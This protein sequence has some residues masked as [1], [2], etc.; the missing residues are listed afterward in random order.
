MVNVSVSEMT[1]S[2]FSRICLEAAAWSVPILAGACAVTG[3]GIVFENKLE[4]A[5]L[6]S[7]KAI[8]HMRIARRR[9]WRSAGAAVTGR[10]TSR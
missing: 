2:G 9:A 8:V 1:I 7:Q 5:H 3:L 4:R 6:R 10:R